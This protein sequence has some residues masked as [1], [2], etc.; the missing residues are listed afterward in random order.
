MGKISRLSFKEDLASD[1]PIAE[2]TLRYY[3]ISNKIV[4]KT[5]EIIIC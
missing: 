2:I 3:L 5:T 4:K 1:N